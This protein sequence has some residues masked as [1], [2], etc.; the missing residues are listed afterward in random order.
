M[1]IKIVIVAVLLALAACSNAEEINA[2]QAA[3]E[4]GLAGSV[5][6]AKPEQPAQVAPGAHPTPKNRPSELDRLLREGAQEKG[7]GL[8]RLDRKRD[9]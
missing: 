6:H 9:E 7:P 4:K 3:G 1:K 2:A 8:G 5:S